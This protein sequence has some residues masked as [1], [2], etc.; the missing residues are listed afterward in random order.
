M[1]YFQRPPRDALIRALPRALAAGD[2][3]EFHWPESC[4]L[5]WRFD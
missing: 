3:S 4:D 5:A 2:E 1:P